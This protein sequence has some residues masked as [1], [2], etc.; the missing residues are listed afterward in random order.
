MVSNKNDPAL[1]NNSIAVQ[2]LDVDLF[3]QIK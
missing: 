3:L 2:L 1:G